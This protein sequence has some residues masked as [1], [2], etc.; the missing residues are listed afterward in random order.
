MLDAEIISNAEGYAVYLENHTEDQ[1]ISVYTYAGII[2]N[3]SEVGMLLST[4]EIT[5]FNCNMGEILQVT[6]Q[7]P[8]GGRLDLNCVVKRF[9]ESSA[10]ETT[11]KK[12]G[13][14]VMDPPAVFRSFVRS[15][16]DESN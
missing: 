10:P 15:I 9:Q 6:F 4:S 7:L 16:I 8:S 3:I 5:H 13:I 1:D 12:I 2:E 14:E 11:E